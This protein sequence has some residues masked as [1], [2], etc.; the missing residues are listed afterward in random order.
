MLDLVLGGDSSQ[1]L[2]VLCL[3][4]HCDDLEIGCGG[5]ILELA[6]LRRPIEV[7]WEVFASSEAR[8]REARAAAAA[9]LEGFRA[10]RV[11]IHAFRESYFPYVAAEVKD[12][13]EGIKSDCRPDLVLTHHGRDKHQ[14]HRLISELTWNTFR[15]HLILE[16]EIPKYDAD[17]GQPNAF[18]PIDEETL[19]RKIEILLECFP[20]QAGRGW[21]DADTFR[22]LARLRGVECGSP[23]R[24]AEAFHSRKTVLGLKGPA[25]PA[26]PA[27]PADGTTEA[28][29]SRA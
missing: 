24:F 19:E 4:A 8:E 23:T 25:G 29:G 15:N 13:F 22:G 21:F 28:Q 9:F 14:D 7:H 20:S 3:G 17:L 27:T 18:V 5:T 10:S 1:P 2:S 6:A 12:A 26:S 16:Y 11:E